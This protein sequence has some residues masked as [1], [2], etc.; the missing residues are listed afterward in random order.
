MASI[1]SSKN[2]HRRILFYDVDKTRKTLHMGKC[3]MTLARKVQSRVE[4]V[5]SAKLLGGPVPQDDAT[6]LASDGRN[7]KP[8]F[9]AIGLIPTLAPKRS[10]ESTVV[11][12]LTDFI[13]RVGKTK[14]PGTVAPK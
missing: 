6:W 7:L 1:T 12:H 4:S 2:G 3:S 9:E 8:K 10:D 11:A 5:L 14:K 13:E